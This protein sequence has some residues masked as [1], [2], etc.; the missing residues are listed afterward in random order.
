MKLSQSSVCHVQEAGSG[1]NTQSPPESSHMCLGREPGFKG[2]FNKCHS[3]LVRGGE[4][5]SKRENSR[6]RYLE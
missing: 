1:D 4:K 6:N 3:V 5:N 2:R